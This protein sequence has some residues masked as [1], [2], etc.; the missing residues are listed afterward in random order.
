MNGIRY[1]R[2]R[3]VAHCW[4][5][6]YDERSVCCCFW[7]SSTLY[8]HTCAILSNANLNHFCSTYV[9]DRICWMD[10]W[11][12]IVY[13]N[14]TI[15]GVVCT[16]ISSTS[17]IS[18]ALLL[19]LFLLCFAP[20]LCWLVIHNNW[21]CIRELT[22]ASNWVKRNQICSNIVKSKFNRAS[23]VH[24]SASLYGWVGYMIHHEFSFSFYFFF[25]A[26]FSWDWAMNSELNK[27]AF[28]RT[29]LS[30]SRMYDDDFVGTNILVFQ[31]WIWDLKCRWRTR[32]RMNATEWETFIA[33]AT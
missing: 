19:L 18:F 13:S 10:T 1:K 14:T 12:T 29:Q 27:D 24:M 7:L 8:T 25:C 32:R 20:C 2:R 16:T 11:C 26:S 21:S 4:I 3:V 22:P 6:C 17:I 33:V 9:K 15:P 28:Q 23:H 5:I 31:H 30:R